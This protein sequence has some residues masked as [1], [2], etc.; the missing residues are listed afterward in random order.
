M[1]K[2]LN[3]NM[4]SAYNPWW[5]SNYSSINKSKF[6]AYYNKFY[7]F[8]NLKSKGKFIIINT[9]YNECSV[10]QI[11]YKYVNSR[12]S[13]ENIVYIPFENLGYSDVISIF[14]EIQKSPAKLDIFVS[15]IDPYL[16][17]S[18]D[19]GKSLF[20][21]INNSKSIR[22]LFISTRFLPNSASN[23]HLSK[24]AGGANHYTINPLTFKEYLTIFGKRNMKNY[25]ATLPIIAKSD[26]EY[27]EKVYSQACKIKDSGYEHLFK[28]MFYSYSKSGGFISSITEYNNKGNLYDSIYN[29]KLSL[30]REFESLKI[31][32]YDMEKILSAITNSCG[33][34]YTLD[35]MKQDTG[36]SK[37][38]ILYYY[39]L[40]TDLGIIKSVLK[41]DI[42]EHKKTKLLRK[43]Y[44]TD[45]I[46]YIAFSNS[47]NNYSK[48][49][50]QIQGPIIE[51]IV[52]IELTRKFGQVYT[53]KEGVEVDFFLPTLNLGIEVKSG[54]SNYNSYHM[55]FPKNRVVF[56][57][58]KLKKENGLFEIPYYLFL[59]LI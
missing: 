25:L 32:N 11:L 9:D 36:I 10:K 12:K 26:S 28:E 5:G 29:Y 59:A 35:S 43:T 19:K 6:P 31:S 44:L 45:P 57:S 16:K 30:M 55:K 24:L 7:K 46:T 53:L 3:N 48:T 27:I 4:L 18:L 40:L 50:I 47:Y 17:F 8:S 33:S 51:N 13:R 54:R 2:Q 21:I 22:R 1:E 14:N 52:G 34:I 15:G 58:D 37:E 41:F 38:S 49:E 56:N 23:R 39:R 42:K 20:N